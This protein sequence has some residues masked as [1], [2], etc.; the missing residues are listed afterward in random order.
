MAIR[1]ER[2]EPEFSN[3]MV[4]SNKMPRPGWKQ[5]DLRNLRHLLSKESEKPE[6]FMRLTNVLRGKTERT[7]SVSEKETEAP[8][9]IS[10]LV[11]Y[12]RF[13]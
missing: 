10:R 13:F 8:R 7:K 1:R 3:K 12:G 2:A 5:S 4:S 9:T 6:A 11:S